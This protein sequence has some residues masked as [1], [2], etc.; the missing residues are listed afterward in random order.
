MDHGINY[1]SGDVVTEVLALT[2]RKGANLVVDPVGGRTLEA[3]I[4]A[5]A[6]RGA[7][8]GSDAPGARTAARHLAHHAAQRPASR[9]CSSAPRWC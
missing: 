3:S 1:A 4:A 2:D 9:V 8:A 5:L 7:S 6:Y